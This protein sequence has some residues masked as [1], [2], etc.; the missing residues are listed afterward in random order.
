MLCLPLLY[1][2]DKGRNASEQWIP[3]EDTVMLVY[4]STYD[5]ISPTLNTDF[6]A[7]LWHSNSDQH[8]RNCE[9]EYLLRQ[10]HARCVC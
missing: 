2:T 4:I 8:R 9:G 1:H 10:M 3:A 7:C 6:W 5:A